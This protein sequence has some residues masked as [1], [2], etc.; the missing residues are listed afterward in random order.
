MEEDKPPSSGS[1]HLLFGESALLLGRCYECG[2]GVE[3]I[4][5]PRAASFYREAMVQGEKDAAVDLAGLLINGGPA[6]ADKAAAAILLR[7]GA[8]AGHTLSQGVLGAVMVG[9]I[10]APFIAEDRDEAA[11]L[12]ETAASTGLSFAIAWLGNCYKAGFGVQKD[13]AKAV[14]LYR[15]AIEADEGKIP[16]V[17]SVHWS[18]PARLELADCYLTGRGVQQDPAE[19]I[20]LLSREAE[21]GCPAAMSSLATLYREGRH[22][23]VD[24]GLAVRLFQQAAELGDTHGMFYCGESSN[25]LRVRDARGLI[26]LTS[27][28]RCDSYAFSITPV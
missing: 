9:G 10:G 11:R 4:D 15:R 3:K 2:R 23:A 6:V 18:S 8:D 17:R 24:H 13:A 21:L 7:Q 25:T 22:I 14:Q 5:E 12:L 16:P 27:T 1:S 19:A 20:L 28:F 26:P